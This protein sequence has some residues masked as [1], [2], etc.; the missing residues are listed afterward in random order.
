MKSAEACPP[1]ILKFLLSGVGGHRY[2]IA[3]RQKYSWQ[4]SNF[5]VLGK[6]SNQVFITI[7]C[8]E[9][10]EIFRRLSFQERKEFSGVT[11]DL[12]QI[13]QNSI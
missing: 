7:A 9:E 11:K 12:V 5:L 8:F 10:K 1:W 3:Q 4:G 2:Y 6:N 13:L